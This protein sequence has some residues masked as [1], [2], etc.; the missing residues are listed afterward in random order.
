MGYLPFW[1]EFWIVSCKLCNISDQKS[2]TRPWWLMMPIK[3]RQSDQV[4]P[5]SIVSNKQNN[6]FDSESCRNCS[7]FTPSCACMLISYNLQHSG[8]VASRWWNA[9]MA[10]IWQC[11]NTISDVRNFQQGFCC[12]IPVIP[13]TEI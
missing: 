10:A 4:T 13:K 11:R 12:K 8:K 3:F 7:V 6:L 9:R 5:D 1:D 2:W